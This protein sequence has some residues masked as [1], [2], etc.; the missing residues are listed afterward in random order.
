MRKKTKFVN[1]FLQVLHIILK[2]VFTYFNLIFLIISIL[3]IMAKS[4]K[5]LTFLPIIIFNTLIGIIQ[6]LRAKKVLDKLTLINEAK[7]KI[8]RDGKKIEVINGDL[9]VNDIILLESGQQIPADAKVIEGKINV[10]E[11]LLTGEADEIEKVADSKLMSGSFVVSGYAKA[12]LEAVGKDAYISK[13]TN[14]AKE[15]K[16]KKSEMVKDIET[17]IK[18]AGVVIIPVGIMLFYQSMYVNNVGFSTAVTS[19]VGAVIGMIPEGLYLLVTIALALSAMRLAKCEVLLHDMRSTETLARVDVLCVDKTGT[20]TNNK[21]DITEVFNPNNIKEKDNKEVEKIL[22][23]YL[24]TT[25][26]N[27]STSKALKEYFPS[28]ETLANAEVIPFSSKIKYSQITAKNETYRLGA[29]EFVLSKEIYKKHLKEINI[30]TNRGDRVLVFAKKVDKEFIPLIFIAMKNGIRAN[31]KD[32]FKYFIDQEVKV[33]VISGDNPVTV[34]KIASQVEI[35]NANDY[36]D[37]TTLITDEDIADAVNKYTIFGRVKPEQKKRIVEAFKKKGLKV[38]MTG[39]GVNDI[40][41]MKEADCSIAMGEGSQAA[42]QAAQVV[43]LD[44]DFSH[45]KEIISEGRRDINN[46]TRSSILFLYKN[47]FSVLLAVFSIIS[48][49]EY[50][51]EPSQVSLVSAF[52]IGIPAFLLAFEYDTR[53]Q[54]GSFLKE[55]LKRAIPVALTSFFAIVAMVAFGYVF[56]ISEKEISTASTYLL[57]IAGFMILFKLTKPLN[58]YRKIVIGLCILGFILSTTFLYKLFS[59]N[60]LSYQCVMLTVLFAIAEESLLR[61]LTLIQQKREIKINKNKN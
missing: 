6:Q 38:A 44:S 52:N 11:S 27:N 43:L 55:T 4:Y 60:D 19:M 1:N 22:A 28:T 42:M 21:M 24:I 61:N 37:A 32:T 25:P 49:I 46:L 47:I 59:I 35:P 2:N 17:I 13:L 20:I 31:V 57:S 23:S 39:D 34:S 9:K 50:P 56:S 54:H 8:I 33:V 7:Y 53:K 12:R 26:D 15:I 41:A 48:V 36:I 10:N 5:N 40:I 58:R 29:P 45:M 18:I 51:L 3:L 16:E 14:K 30:R